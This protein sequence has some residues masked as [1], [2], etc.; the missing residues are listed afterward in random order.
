MKQSIALACLFLVACA[1]SIV[2]AAASDANLADRR[3][4]AESLASRDVDAGLRDLRAL[5]AQGDVLSALD[6][7]TILVRRNQY[8]EALVI[9]RPIAE[10][11]NAD[12]QWMMAVA[13][14]DDAPSH[15]A[16]FRMWVK[17]A[18]AGGQSK[19]QQ[20]LAQIRAAPRPLN[21]GTYATADW[22]SY[23]RTMMVNRLS[24]MPE[25]VVA[26]YGVPRQ[27]M[28]SNVEVDLATCKSKVTDLETTSIGFDDG[29]HLAATL[30]RCLLAESYRYAGKT[31]PE[32]DRCTPGAR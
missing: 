21:D 6:V 5:A 19:A 23:A 24:A 10:A 27:K 2:A 18:A 11:G 31:E 1:T 26:C 7:G 20:Y 3:R 17:R 22:I 9:L 13:L 32:M 16:E 25:G 8:D 28:L 30:S 4:A 29:Q 15:Q 14:D 12:A